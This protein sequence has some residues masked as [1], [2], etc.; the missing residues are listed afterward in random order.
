[1][2]MM[3][4]RALKT[5]RVHDWMNSTVL[6]LLPMMMRRIGDGSADGSLNLLL[7]WSGPPPRWRWSRPDE[8]LRGQVRPAG[9]PAAPWA[10]VWVATGTTWRRR[11]PG[12][13]PPP[14][15]RRPPWGWWTSQ[16]TG[17]PVTCLAPG[18]G[19]AAAC[20]WSPLHHQGRHPRPG[21][22]PG[23][24][25]LCCRPQSGPGPG[26]PGP[27]CSAPSAWSRSSCGRASCST[28]CQCCPRVGAPRQPRPRGQGRFPTGSPAR[29]CCDLSTRERRPG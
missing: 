28:R 2:N 23:G 25:C 19:S 10:A 26:G 18:S 13:R 5:L 27:R 17:L 14:R 16:C 1:M 8:S 29:T 9:V 22:C 15:R 21:L 3:M 24:C 20:W 11:P 7:E 4:Q 6:Q 12:Q